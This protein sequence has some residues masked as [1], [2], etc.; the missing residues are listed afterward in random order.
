MPGSEKEEAMKAFY[1]AAQG[2]QLVLNKW[3]TI[4]V[5]YNNGH[6]VTSSPRFRTVGYGPGGE[7]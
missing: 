4:Q 2:D 5:G 1:T 7:A 6:L 3:F